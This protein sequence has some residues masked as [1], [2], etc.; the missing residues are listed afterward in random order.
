MVVGTGSGGVKIFMSEQPY[1]LVM[2]TRSTPCPF[3]SIAKRVLAAEQV[4]YRE[5]FIDQNRTY[6]Q[7]VL[8]WTG[9]LSVPTLVV[10]RQGEE[11]PIAEPSFLE[12]GATPRGVNRGSM[13]TEPGEDQLLNWLREHGFIGARTEASSS[14][15]D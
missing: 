15:A 12:K 1:E 3:V 11:L 6:E 14:S 2:Y 8:T 4:A 5:L 10:A 13:I 7:R 9:F